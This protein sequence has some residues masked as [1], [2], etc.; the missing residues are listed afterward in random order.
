MRK[1]VKK[2]RYNILMEIC[3]IIKGYILKD[4]LRFLI[5]DLYK[6]NSSLC[7]NLIF[8]LCILRDGYFNRD[9]YFDCLEF[10]VDIDVNTFFLNFDKLLERGRIDDFYEFGKRI[11]IKFLGGKCTNNDY[12]VLDHIVNYYADRFEK[13]KILMS[14]ERNISLLSRYADH[15]KSNMGMTI[16]VINKMGL[17][18]ILQGMNYGIEDLCLFF[19]R[20]MGYP[21][22][23]CKLG[24]K[25]VYLLRY[26][27]ETCG[28]L[29][30]WERQVVRETNNGLKIFRK[31][32]LVA[33]SKYIL[34][35]EKSSNDELMKNIMSEGF[36]GKNI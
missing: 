18:R 36:I 2:N 5:D 22:G 29:L 28:D 16:L 15:Q 31:D 1:V 3:D 9:I 24:R 35:R 20:E 23:C 6:K 13:D 30:D 21:V 32:Y 14:G 25:R 10:I 33:M 7:W 27:R 17:I 34:E 19:F 12:R 26:V 4:D 8:G 11:L